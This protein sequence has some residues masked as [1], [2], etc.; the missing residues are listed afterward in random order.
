MSKKKDYQKQLEGH[1]QA[2]A[3]HL[4]KIEEERHRPKPREWL[5]KLWEKQIANIRRQIEKLE[6]R[7][8]R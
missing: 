5:I 1:R 7:L 2:L 4:R 8:Q 3:E 6:R